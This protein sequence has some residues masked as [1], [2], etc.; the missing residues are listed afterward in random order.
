VHENE[1][2]SLSFFRYNLL[3]QCWELEPDSRPRFNSLVSTISRI[4]EISADY[5]VFT[6]TSANNMDHGVETVEGNMTSQF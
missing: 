2:D 3:L 6:D 1:R 5:L 4:L